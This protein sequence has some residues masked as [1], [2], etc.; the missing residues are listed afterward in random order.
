[1]QRNS[2]GLTV[3]FHSFW[4]IDRMVE[5]SPVYFRASYS[6]LSL[7]LPN[8]IFGPSSSQA[9]SA[10]FCPRGLFSLE[11]IPQIVRCVLFHDWLLPSGIM[12]FRV[13][14]CCGRGPRPSLSKA[15]S[16]PIVYL[17]INHWVLGKFLLL[18]TVVNTDLNLCVLGLG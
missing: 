7:C 11:H 17:V 18:A 1:M 16:R 5:T 12:N 3:R 4:N 6:P 15:K 10:P 13:H 14:L 8:C 2:A 9:S